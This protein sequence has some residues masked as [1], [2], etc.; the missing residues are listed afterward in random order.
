MTA[1][2]KYTR[3]ALLTAAIGVAGLSLNT[4]CNKGDDSDDRGGTAREQN[5]DRYDKPVQDKP[6]GQGE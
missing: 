3:T 4:G 2:L 6:V 5:K 1:W